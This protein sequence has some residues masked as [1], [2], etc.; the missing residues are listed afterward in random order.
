MIEITKETNIAELTQAHPEA[1]LV[2][3]DYGLHCVGCAINAFDTIQMG[4]QIHGMS[5][6]EIEEMIVKIKD[7]IGGS[8]AQS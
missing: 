7:A 4:A 8:D 6:E 5:D 1:A 3:L 2:M